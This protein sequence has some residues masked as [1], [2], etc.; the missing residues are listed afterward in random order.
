TA[1]DDNS[2]ITSQTDDN[3]NATN[4][5]YDALNRRTITVYA[6]CTSDSISHDEHN[7]VV[8]S[9]DENGTAA[10]YSYDALNRLTSKNIVTFGP[11]VSS[12]T[13]SENY[14]YDGLS[15]LIVA[16]D[17]DTMVTRG[18]G[19]TSGYDSLSDVLRETQ[20]IFGIGPG[21]S[22]RTITAIF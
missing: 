10:N 17:N 4:Y 16:T 21:G 20:E 7:N 12:E 1:Y 19:G 2:R 15:R 11:G 5:F 13:T 22:Q 6:D 8:A 14:Q 18:T 3:N 9:N